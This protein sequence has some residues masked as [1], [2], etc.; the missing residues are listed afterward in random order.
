MR[1]QFE[2]LCIYRNIE[3]RRTSHDLRAVLPKRLTVRHGYRCQRMLKDHRTLFDE[4][5]ILPRT[6]VLNADERALMEL[7]TATMPLGREQ[8][9]TWMSVAI[10][11]AINHQWEPGKFHL[12]Y[13]SSG[14][15]SRIIS[16]AI[17]RLYEAQGPDWLGA[18]LFVCIG[19][20]TDGFVDIMRAEGWDEWAYHTIPDVMPIM[21]RMLDVNYAGRAFN[22]VSVQALDYN[23]LLTEYLQEQGLIP[24]EDSQI[25]LFSGRNET[26]MGATMP[27][28]NGLRAS[29]AEQYDSVLSVSRYKAGQV[30]WPF[31]DYT[32][33]NLGLASTYRLDWSTPE[34][35]DSDGVHFRRDIGRILCPA[36]AEI[37]RGTLHIPDLA[38]ER[39]EQ[40]A[41]EYSRTWYG[42]M[43]WPDAR[44]DT[45]GRLFLRHPWWGAFTAAALCEA[46][47]REGYE[48]NV[49]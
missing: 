17:R 25:Q 38:P 7:P 34:R 8:F 5:E 35:E 6:E 31:L 1:R 33:I 45:T 36:F 30:V 13:H 10:T 42:M 28:G 48:L 26:L 47:I 20:E 22:G 43:V 29:W 12:V 19:N 49:G 32:V 3:T 2:P 40:M 21:D 24:A 23:W 16:A 37:P 41:V 9:L 18:V 46:L 39:V 11:G 27:A 4:I 44:Q 15:D 14:W